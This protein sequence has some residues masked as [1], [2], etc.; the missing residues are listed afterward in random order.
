VEAL[1][2]AGQLNVTFDRQTHKYVSEHHD[3]RESVLSKKGSAIPTAIFLDDRYPPLSAV[4][5][6]VA[7]PDTV[8]LHGDPYVIVAHNPLAR[9]KVPL[10]IL[11][12]SEEWVVDDLQP[13]HVKL[14]RL[15]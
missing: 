9:N 8:A 5:A 6:T 3:F 14:K 15:A 12:A 2:G 7:L 11:G 13:G 4:L 10:G 1:F